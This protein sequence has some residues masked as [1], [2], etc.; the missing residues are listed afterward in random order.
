MQAEAGQS[1]SG[2]EEEFEDSRDNLDPGN[3]IEPPTSNPGSIPGS[4]EV[5]APPVPTISVSL[6]GQISSREVDIN[7]IEDGALSQE[8]LS[9]DAKFYQDVA[10]YYQNAY[11]V[12]FVQQ[13]ELQD[14]FKAQSCLM[15]EASAAI[16]AAETEVQQHHQDVL[17]LRHKNQKEV[18]SAVSRVAEH[19]KVQLTSAQG[20]LQS[21][22]LKHKLEIQKQQEKIHTLEVSLASQGASNLPSVGVS[23]QVQSGTV[24]QRRFLTLSQ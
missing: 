4:M 20:S 15:E 24:L 7:Q 6:G 11:E 19:Y 2:S 10:L 18:D 8:D 23:H 9:E 21:W 3:Q 16:H 22:D 5:T 14:K 17:H 13:V 1:E 12:L